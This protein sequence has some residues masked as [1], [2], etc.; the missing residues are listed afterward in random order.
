MVEGIVI[1]VVIGIIMLI[2]NAVV[3]RVNIQTRT[4]RLDKDIEELKEGQ[5]V[6]FKALIAVLIAQRDGKT[7]GEC[8]EALRALNE[9]LIR[10]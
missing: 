9:F 5:K 3:H 6:I 8:K 10:K 4:D 1:G 2:V 7:N